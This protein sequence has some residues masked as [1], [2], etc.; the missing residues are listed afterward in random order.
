MKTLT[1]IQNLQD[2]VNKKIVFEP[3]MISQETVDQFGLITGDRSE[4][5]GE[6]TEGKFKKP[7]VQGYLSLSLFSNY[8]KRT[9]QISG[10]DPVNMGADN[11]RFVRP[12]YIGEPFIPVLM[13]ESVEVDP[14]YIKVLWKYELQNEKSK[15]LLSAVIEARYYH[16]T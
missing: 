12:I 3:R 5:N 11:V 2:S 16:I 8:L 10:T 15:L 7:L 4:H 6:N 13:I 9:V 1:T 14:K